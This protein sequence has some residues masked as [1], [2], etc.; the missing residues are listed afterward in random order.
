[1][2]EFS[3]AW[4]SCFCSC[5][6]DPVTSNPDTSTWPRYSEMYL[7]TENE[8]SRSRFMKVRA[9]TGQPYRRTDRQT[10]PNA[11]LQ[12]HSWV[13]KIITVIINEVI[14]QCPSSSQMSYQFKCTTTTACRCTFIP[15][16]KNNTGEPNVMLD[17]KF[18]EIL[19]YH[20]SSWRITATG[21]QL[22][23]L[24][25]KRRVALMYDS[26]MRPSLYK[27]IFIYWDLLTFPYDCVTSK[28]ITE[29]YSV[30]TR[31]CSH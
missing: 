24:L 17:A 25:I 3:Y 19:F 22:P 10:R 13:V 5:N 31:H 26:V 29:M 9:Q 8:V 2:G 14:F 21:L 27:F 20:Y 6:P 11:L 23:L 28:F 1:M 18:T 7:H 16:N 12:L 4:I 15:E 30:N